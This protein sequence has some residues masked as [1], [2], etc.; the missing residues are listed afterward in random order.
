MKKIGYL[1][2]EGTY[3]HFAAKKMGAN[4]E[5]VPMENFPLIIEGLMDGIIDYAVLPIENTLNGG[6]LQNLDLLQTTQD[7]FAFRSVTIRV[8]HRLAMRESADPRK[9][10]AIYSHPQALAQ[11]SKF[12]SSHFP[13]AQLLP[14]A[15][16]SASVEMITSDTVAGI[17]SSQNKREGLKFYGGNIA[18]EKHNFT[19]FLLVRRGEARNA[20]SKRI[21]F[22][23]T[24]AHKPGSLLGF[25]QII[26][27]R[28]LNMTKI[29]SRPVK[30]KPGEYRFFIEIEANYKE[31]EVKTSLSAIRAAAKSFKLLGCY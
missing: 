6:V 15:S 7:V 3:S 29:E 13:H 10:T 16:T 23:A 22:C 26:A 19:R 28:G 21:Y 11:C 20:P 8:D 12:L 14:T 24:L 5:L 9:I 25:L 4:A 30:D 2:P 31:E 1:G 17:I 27:D 18:D